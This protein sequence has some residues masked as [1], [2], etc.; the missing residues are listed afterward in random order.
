MTRMMREILG[1]AFFVVAVIIVVLALSG[2][3]PA[4]PVCSAMD[5]TKARCAGTEV[6]YCDGKN[7]YPQ[8]DCSNATDSDGQ[9]TDMVCVSDHGEPI[10]ESRGGN[11]AD[12]R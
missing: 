1:I 4:Y 3:T 9:P 2:C 5:A 11:D 6:E 12:L 8:F 10:C 7:W